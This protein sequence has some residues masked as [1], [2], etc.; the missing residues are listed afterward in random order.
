MS[1]SIQPATQPSSGAGAAEQPVSASSTDRT[2]ELVGKDAFLRLL[3][4]QIKNQNPLDP[5]DGVQF[6]TQLAQF[7]ELEQL[8]E[9]R[10]GLDAFRQQ[11]GN[12]KPAEESTGAA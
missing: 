12:A 10:Q 9:I 1:T 11:F 5:A 4:A 2:T 6:L 7:S 3:V 8:I